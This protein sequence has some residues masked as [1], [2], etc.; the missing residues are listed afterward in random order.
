MLGSPFDSLVSKLRPPRGSAQGVPRTAL[1]E[2]LNHAAGTP[3]VVCCADPGYGKTTAL[4]QWADSP[5]QRRFAWV[6]GSA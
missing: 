6:S 1:I 5:G 3:I 4:S 2:G